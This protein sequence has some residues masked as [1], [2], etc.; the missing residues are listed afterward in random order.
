M[1]FLKSAGL[2]YSLSGALF[3]MAMYQMLDG[4]KVLS[5]GLISLV[6]LLISYDRW[7]REFPDTDDW[8]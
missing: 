1:K 8:F 4:D 3:S 6:T 2:F 5:W 7:D